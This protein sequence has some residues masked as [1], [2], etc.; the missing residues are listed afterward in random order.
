[1]SDSPYP[2]LK[3]TH[4]MART[5][6]P[7]RDHKPAASGPVWQIIQGYG[8]YF[9]LLAACELGVFDLLAGGPATTEELAGELAV[10]RHHLASL[11]D[12]L[13]VLGFLE[14]VGDRVEL[15]DVA[16]RYL[17]RS[18]P[19]SMVDLVAVAPGP[20]ENW[21]TLA[22]TVRRGRPARPV[23]DD[24]VSFYRP[25][26]E[27]TFATQH[28]AATRLDLRIGVSR[29]AAPRI[30]DLGAG[31]APWS[32]AFLERCPAASA[33]VNDLPGVVELAADVAAE[34]G[35]YDRVELRS[36]DYLEIRVEPGAYDVVVLGHLLRTEGP[37][38]SQQLVQRAFDALRPGGRV[39]VADYFTDGGRSLHPFG[40]LMGAT[41]AAST[42][43]GGPLVHD[44][45]AE[46]LRGA[47]FR[48]VRLLEP[49]GFN[50]VL[51]GTRPD[52][53]RPRSD[54]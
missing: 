16:E 53:S 10:S 33:V 39:I 38:R 46:W 28:R 26:V 8:N 9:T 43:R 30:L 14:A 13:V 32:I 19:A 36:G 41:M 12:A 2:E 1:M 3:K 22:D 52:T 11:L 29:I 42:E 4:T 44:E 7:W 18:S 5:G 49:I 45:V 6:R 35:L 51:V 48:P 40:V 15:T 23:D 21:T 47:G 34:R 24:P 54:R 37:A 20:L 25:L 50:Q 17:V 31:G 27:A